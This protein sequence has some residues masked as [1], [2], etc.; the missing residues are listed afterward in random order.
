MKSFLQFLKEAAESGASVQAKKLN[1]KSD[2]HGGWYDSRGEFV[3]KTEGGKLKFYDKNQKIGERD[4]NQN[5]NQVAQKQDETKQKQKKEEPKDSS[6]KEAP[7]EEGQEQ[8]SDTL[9]VVFG[10]FNPPTVGHEKLLSMAKKAS[11]GG[12]FKVYPS[13]SQDAKKNPLDPDMKISFMKKMFSDYEENII[14]DPDMKN[15]FDVLTTA[16]EDGYGNVNIVVGSDRQAE[17]ENL[18]QK[19]NG[20]LYEF[21]LIRVISAGVRD[22]D[23]EGVEGMSASKMRKAVMDDDFESFRRGTPKKLDDGDT[24][25]LFNAVRQGMKLKKKAKVTAEMWQVAPKLDPKGL[26]EQYVSERIFRIGDI[27]ENLNT[28]MIGEIIR[29]GTNHLICVTKENFMFKSWVKD[30][31]EAVVNYPGPSGVSGP[32]REVGTD[33]LRKYTERMTGTSAIKNF[34]NKYKAKK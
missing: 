12:D 7:P 31:M 33:S 16:N 1:L 32:E 8:Q 29:R 21:D 18:A 19:Y 17:F 25:A 23:A 20:Q 34:I 27:V 9:T 28:G 5:T 4:G 15:I 24:Q 26:R 6:K 14:N 13:R 3:A 11:S 22:A 30:V 2:G 10:R